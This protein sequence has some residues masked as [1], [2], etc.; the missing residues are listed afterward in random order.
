[1]RIPIT[2]CHGVTTS[3]E[4]PLD[5]ARFESYFRIAAGMDFRSISYDDL[6]RARTEGGELPVRPIMFD[7]DHPSRS[8]IQDILPLMQRYGFAGNLFINTGPMEEMYA[9]GEAASPDRKWLSWEEIA[10]L[11]KA[12]WHIGAHTHSHPNLSELSRDDPAGEKLREELVRCDTILE[13]ALGIVPKDFAF[14]GVSW[15]S[16]AEREVKKRYRFG[17]LWIVGT[18][19]SADGDTIRYSELAGVSGDDEPDGGPPVAARYITLESNPYRLPS[20][21]LSRLIYDYDA[22]RRY[23]EGALAGG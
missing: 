9:S 21:E 17:R 2:M 20:M 8:L 22:Y 1:M 4:R 11:R 10:A 13:G 15:S 7:F 12:S 3:G 14:T 5:I 6:G 23:L 16:L 19:Y 18:T